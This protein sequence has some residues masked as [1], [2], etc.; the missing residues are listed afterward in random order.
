M[1]E[2][3]KDGEMDLEQA[4]R[5]TDIASKIIEIKKVECQ[6][7]SILVKAGYTHQVAAMLDQPKMIEE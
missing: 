3:V 5:A 2:M 4:K 7:A 6:Q 1:L